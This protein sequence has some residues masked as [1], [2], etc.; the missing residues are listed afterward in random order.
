MSETELTIVP[1]EAIQEVRKMEYTAFLNILSTFC[2]Q[3]PELDWN[4]EMVLHSFRYLLD[5]PDKVFLKELEFRK[6][7][8]ETTNI[9]RIIDRTKSQPI[10][11]DHEAKPTTTTHHKTPRPKPTTPTPVRTPVPRH[12]TPPPQAQRQRQ[13]KE[14]GPPKASHKPPPPPPEPTIRSQLMTL[15]ES[16]QIP[17]ISSYQLPSLSTI[18]EA[19]ESQPDHLETIKSI[20]IRHMSNCEIELE[21]QKQH[22]RPA[23]KTRM[24]MILA[25][26]KKWARI[27]AQGGVEDDVIDLVDDALPTEG[28][29]KD[30]ETVQI[31]PAEE[32]PAE[33][34]MVKDPADEV[35]AEEGVVK[36]PAEIEETEHGKEV[37]EDKSEKAEE[38]R[39]PTVEQKDASKEENGLTTEE[40][41]V[42]VEK[43]QTP[44]EEE[45]KSGEKTNDLEEI[46]PP[47]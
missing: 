26:E 27:R 2:S 42:H 35:P 46:L 30:E 7:D 25:K 10:H 41:D 43:K 32:P 37:L 24:K 33:E 12:H 17:A 4:Q 9:A 3:G 20:C 1:S 22:L 5:I 21:K 11:M 47:T 13:V 34:G 19:L 18:K 8:T 40:N 45:E 44:V 16:I 28:M 39:E 36:E 38:E 14:P 6:H 23:D 29:N 31:K 15:P